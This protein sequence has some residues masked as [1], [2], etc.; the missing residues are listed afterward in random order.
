MY[1]P[2]K[3]PRTL[4]RRHALRWLGAGAAAAILPSAAA[5]FEARELVFER[6]D[7]TLPQWDADGFKVAVLSD[8]HANR[9]SDSERAHRAVLMALEEKPD[10]IAIPGDFLDQSS[11]LVLENVRRALEPLGDAKCPVVATLGNHDYSV[12]QPERAIEGIRR[13][14]LQLLRNQA[15][16]VQGVTVAGLDDG[17][18]RKDDPSFLRERTFSRS[19]LLLFHE[20]DY[21]ERVPA[22]V[23]LQ[24]SGHSHGGQICLPFGRSIHTPPGAQNYI[25][26]FYPDADVPLYVTRGVGTTGPDWRLFCKPEVSILTLR[27]A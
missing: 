5:D 18:Y 7:L 9:T 16:E 26:G 1:M 12:Y 11:K 22:N 3:S 24:L 6:H 19:L 8:L 14:P 17:M 13:N 20:P 27:G 10:L 23:S 21:V 25:K 2:S 4:T 15:V